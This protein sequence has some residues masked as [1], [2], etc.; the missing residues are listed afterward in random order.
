MALN[1]LVSNITF[2]CLFFFFLLIH[3]FYRKQNIELFS[4]PCFRIQVCKRE[5]WL[6]ARSCIKQNED[7]I[8]AFSPPAPISRYDC[9]RHLVCV[10]DGTVPPHK[11]TCAWMLSGSRL[12]S[13]S[14]VLIPQTL[15]CAL[16]LCPWKLLAWARTCRF[17]ILTLGIP[18]LISLCSQKPDGIMGKKN[19]VSIATWF[20]AWIIHWLLPKDQ[21]N[22]RKMILCCL[23]CFYRNFRLL[24]SL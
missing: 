11:V 23:F 8:P 15:T 9:S 19:A 2:R 17:S 20:D 3:I 5:R 16:N 1:S 24:I 4:G 14:Q 18:S 12:S 13:V 22:L 6:Y 7:I 21:S 10:S